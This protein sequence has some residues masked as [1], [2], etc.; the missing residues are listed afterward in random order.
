M[1]MTFVVMALALFGSVKVFAINPEAPFKN[2]VLK[3]TGQTALDLKSN[4]FTLEG[5]DYDITSLGHA[6]YQKLGRADG[7]N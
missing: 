6:D 2:L 5:Y 4:V 7:Y 1:K 3:C